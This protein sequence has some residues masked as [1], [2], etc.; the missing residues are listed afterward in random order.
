MSQGSESTS[1]VVSIGTSE[2]ELILSD[3]RRLRERIITAWFERGVM[4]T[5]DEQARLRDEIRQTC[6]LL[7]DLTASS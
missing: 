1:N 3:L 2:A 6:S 4:L 5:L 7:T